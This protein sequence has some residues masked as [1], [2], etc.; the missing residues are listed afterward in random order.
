MNFRN[1]T[2]LSIENFK[3]IKKKT[4]V[5]NKLQKLS[6]IPNLDKKT[7]I[8]FQDPESYL[9]MPYETNFRFVIGRKP[10]GPRFNSDHK[11]IPY[12][13]VGSLLK[14]EQQKKLTK[15]QTLVSSVDSSSSSKSIRKSIRLSKAKFNPVIINE[16]IPKEEKKKKKTAYIKSNL[17]NVEILDIFNKSK[18]RIN[19]NKSENFVY[20]KKYYKEIPKIMHQYINKSLLQQERALKNNEK[21]K[22]I[23]KKIENYISKSMKNR[24]RNTKF[25]ND[26]K[27]LDYNSSNLLKYSGTEYRIKVDKIK[28]NEKKK[29]PPLILENP[30]QN[31]EMSLR[32]PNNFIG[33]RREYLNIRTDKNPYWIILTEKNPV[34][35]EKIIIPKVNNMDKEINLK[36]DSNINYFRK[37]LN[38][39]SSRNTYNNSLTSN[40]FEIKGKKLID[41]EEKLVNQLKGNI[42]MID[43]KYDRESLKD[44]IFKTNYSINKHSFT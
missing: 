34:E 28:S 11:L 2:Q 22:N 3:N 29:Y 23:L 24:I 16:I 26:S 20:E 9:K 40:N 38:P 13:V 39:A 36:T 6:V 42:K 1:Y 27:C 25:F 15:K 31:W 5:I 33:E 21:Y 8:L 32:R 17:T 44:I 19:K 18:K 7:N 43:L 10:A 12:T 35:D 41:I 37:N 14:K 30:M 4:F